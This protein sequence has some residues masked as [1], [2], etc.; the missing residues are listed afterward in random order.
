MPSGTRVLIAPSTSENAPEE[1]LKIGVHGSHARE[2]A[3]DEIRASTTIYFLTDGRVRQG[4][5]LTNAQIESLAEGTQMLVGYVHGGYVTAQRSAF[6]IAG[7]KWNHSST[8]YRRPDG[9]ILSGDQIEES[10]IIPMSMVF[11]QR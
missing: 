11:F 10:S 8:F 5:E 7:A 4:T 3:G 9:S 2:L 6:D 1:L